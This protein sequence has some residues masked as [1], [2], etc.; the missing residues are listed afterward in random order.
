MAAGPRP[1]VG[2]DLGGTKT[3]AVVVA[4]DGH[5]LGQSL[6]P[7]PTEGRDALLAM[8]ERAVRESIARAGLSAEAVAGVG[9]G[10]PGVTDAEAGVLIMPPNLPEDCRDLPV[11]ALLGP[12]LGMPVQVDNDANCAA[13]GEHLFGA[14]RG[15]ADMVYV[16]MSTGIGG[17]IVSGGRLVRGARSAGEVGHMALAPD[18]PDRCGCGRHGCWEALSSGTAMAR[19]ARDAAAAGTASDALRRAA[20]GPG[21]ISGKTVIECA[22]AGDATSLAIIARAVQYSGYGFMNLIHVLGPGAIVVGGG[23]THAWDLC[24]APAADWA[25]RHA[26]EAPASAC[27]IVRSALGELVGGIGAAAL[28]FA[29]QA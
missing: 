2:L 26:M 6:H 8:L 17:G 11:R 5:V 24:I 9:V 7:T 29:Q 15:A 3:L 19:Q 28:V 1:V 10:V 14:G 13:L 16:T 22:E 12:R 18:Q 25:L 23:L 27:R 21:G 4:G 20:G